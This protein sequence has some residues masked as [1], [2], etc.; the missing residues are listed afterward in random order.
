MLLIEDSSSG[1]FYQDCVYRSRQSS[2]I[3]FFFSFKLNHKVIG[4]PVRDINFV[5][6][7]SFIL[8]GFN[9]QKLTNMAAVV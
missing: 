5:R 9:M 1:Y 4:K 2:V 7:M 8:Q 6:R 3:L